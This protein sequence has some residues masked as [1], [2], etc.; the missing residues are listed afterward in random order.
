MQP[1]PSGRPKVIQAGGYHGRITA[2]GHLVFVHDGMLLAAPIDL[3]RLELLREP[4]PVVTGLRG[5]TLTG[6]AQF[7]VSDSGL[8]A[9]LPGPGVGGVR[10]Q[11]KGR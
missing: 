3:D 9:Y 2:S 5:N 6:G 4:V 8:L 1:L 10:T 11:L 7:T